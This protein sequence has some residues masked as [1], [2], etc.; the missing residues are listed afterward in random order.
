[1]TTTFDATPLSSIPTSLPSLPTGTYQ[2]PLTVPST[3]QGGC[4]MNTAQISAW[5]CSIPMTPLEMNII[6]IPGANELASKEIMINY[7]SSPLNFYPYG[8]QPPILNSAQVMSLVNDSDY[9]SRGPAWF[10]QI[11][12][13][14]VVVLPQQSLSLSTNSN[15]NSKR[16]Q[17]QPPFGF[18]G[19]KGVAQAGD[20]PWFCYWNGTLLEAFIYVNDTSSSG[21]TP[22][23]P[24][25]PYGTSTYSSDVPSSTSGVQSQGSS[26]SG[27][28]QQ[29]S[30]QFLPQYPKVYKIAE[31]RIPRGGQTVPAYCVAHQIL[32]NG[33]A[34]PLMNSTGQPITIYLNETEPI[35]FEPLQDRGIA[36]DLFERNSVARDEDES[37]GC[38][39]LES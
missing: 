28:S 26:S 6:D 14:K 10:F 27:A 38:V 34:E 24:N 25:D 9:P 17:P 3:A 7:G 32:S 31:R 1:M 8:A 11:P 29:N 12:Y 33:N 19:R 23:S 4:I 22:A 15:S 21:S 20:Q 37:C 16:N 13:S 35:S 2:M 30:P 18:M 36:T 39:W 5:S